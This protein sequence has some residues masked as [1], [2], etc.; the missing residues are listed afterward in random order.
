MKSLMRLDPFRAI[1]SWDPFD[2]LRTMQREMDRMFGR[3]FEEGGVPAK[4]GEDLWVP[5]IESYV[6][7]GVLHIKAE[8]PG[9][10]QKDLEVNVVDRDLVIRGER[11]TEKDEEKKE[12]SYREISYGSF[13]RRFM[14]PEGTDL[15][16]LKATFTNGVLEITGPAPTAAKARKIEVEAAE[17]PKIVAETKVRKAA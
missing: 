3:F 5:T 8:L 7:D 10:E 6:K 11:R 1:R 2:E 12:Y 9:I 4:K 17:T 14:L 15:D 13:E 16:A